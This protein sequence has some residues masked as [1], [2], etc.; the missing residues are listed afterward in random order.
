MPVTKYEYKSVQTI[1][2]V[3]NLG[4]EGWKLIAVSDGWCYMQRVISTR[5]VKSG[6]ELLTEEFLKAFAYY[7]KHGN[8]RS[9]AIRWQQLLISEKALIRKHLPDYVAAT[10][11]RGK[12]N[13]SKIYR[14]NFE[15]YLNQKHWENDLPR[16]IVNLAQTMKQKG[17]DNPDYINS[18]E[19]MADLLKLS[20][21]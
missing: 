9:S 15:T 13:G 19:H 20:S 2:E 1:H 7:G 5:A 17:L 16:A 18:K 12:G 3:S 21:K 14:K 10:E 6:P 4:A 11:L 8:R